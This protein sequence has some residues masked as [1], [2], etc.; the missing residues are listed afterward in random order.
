MTTFRL[1]D[2]KIRYWRNKYYVGWHW[3]VVNVLE[4]DGGWALTRI[5]ATNAAFRHLAHQSAQRWPTEDLPLS[6]EVIGSAASVSHDNCDAVID[7]LQKEIVV[8]RGE[9][10]AHAEAVAWH[11]NNRGDVYWLANR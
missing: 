9:L 11:H 2:N 1:P 3:Y 7:R 10:A 8:L 4:E 5:G 6:R